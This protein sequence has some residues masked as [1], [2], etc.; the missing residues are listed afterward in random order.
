MFLDHSS[1]MRITKVCSSHAGARS[2]ALRHLGQG[3][4]EQLD[5][6]E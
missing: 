4:A 5:C 6:S 3:E 2:K 1:K